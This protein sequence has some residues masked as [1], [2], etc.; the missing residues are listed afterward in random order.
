M[1]PTQRYLRTRLIMAAVLFT[2]ASFGVLFPNFDFLYIPALFLLQW[3][4]GPLRPV[5]TPRRRL[6]LAILAAYLLVLV[7]F[8]VWN[9]YSSTV[10]SRLG[11]A[12]L[13]WLP[14]MGIVYQ[15]WKSIKN[16]AA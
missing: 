10:L 3:V 8:G 2:A 5:E 4:C 16:A 7:G 6:I 12:L 9:Y 14:G 1:T 13:L 11:L 15:R